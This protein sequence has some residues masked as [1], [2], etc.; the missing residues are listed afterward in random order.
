M[1]AEFASNLFELLFALPVNLTLSLFLHQR[2]STTYFLYPEK[3][4]QAL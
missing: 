2:S 1:S 3:D 4:K